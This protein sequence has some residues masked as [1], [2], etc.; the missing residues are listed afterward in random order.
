MITIIIIIW[1][2]PYSIYTESNFV[3]F[4]AIFCDIH[5][6]MVDHLRL[7]PNEGL[8]LNSPMYLKQLNNN[9]IL[10]M[11]SLGKCW[12][13]FED[14]GYYY[15]NIIDHAI[16][17]DN[18][19][20]VGAL[21]TSIEWL[22]SKMN[23]CKTYKSILTD[24]NKSLEYLGVNHKVM[25]FVVKMILDLTNFY[26]IDTGKEILSKIFNGPNY[27]ISDFRS[28]QERLENYMGYFDNMDYI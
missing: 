20:I 18:N 15:Q 21:A 27:M 13:L 16:A 25:Y 8:E 22:E 19:E 4:S 2:Y 11:L 14:D 9:L 26:S 10:K 3:I 23:A 6:L 1:R 7:P 28:I 24:L 12:H 5:D 17:A